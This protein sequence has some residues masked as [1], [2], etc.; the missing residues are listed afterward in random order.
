MDT[1]VDLKNKIRSYIENADER[2][3]KIINAI[4]EA[5]TDEQGLSQAHK[6]Q[7]EQRLKYH[8]ENPSDGKTWEEIKSSLKKQY[9]L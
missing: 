3:L 6:D 1:I 5:E 9:G 4:I 8:K 7:L 2:I